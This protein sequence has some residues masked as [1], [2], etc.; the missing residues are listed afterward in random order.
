MEVF[1]FLD[2]AVFVVL[3]K[4]LHCDNGWMDGGGENADLLAFRSLSDRSISESIFLWIFFD[5][6]GRWTMTKDGNG[7]EG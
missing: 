2:D 7:A 6:D 3:K 4:Q 5:H 1:W